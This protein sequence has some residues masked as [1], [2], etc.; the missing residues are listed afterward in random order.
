MSRIATAL[1]IVIGLSV[2]A[3]AGTV[4]AQTI[5]WGAPVRIWSSTPVI[6]GRITALSGAS[7]DT[8]RFRDNP[9][10]D[11]YSV[12]R[13]S[14]T[15]V[16][17]R[18]RH[19]SPVLGTFGGILV[20]GVVGAGAGFILGSLSVEH[21]RSVHQCP[22]GDCGLVMLGTIPLGF[23][24]GAISGGIVGHHLAGDKWERVVDPQQI[25]VGFAA[26]PHRGL[27]VAVT[28]PTQ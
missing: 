21:D 28:W 2:A 6:E 19:V 4:N 12:A 20:G 11:E 9:E 17:L 25:R 14:L 1:S 10:S 24:A 26:R 7:D 27:G 5:R 3:S 23:I 16:D 13:Q 22:D 15:R 8:L 18:T